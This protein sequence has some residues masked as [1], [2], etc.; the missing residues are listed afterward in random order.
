MVK[1]FADLSASIAVKN[2]AFDF[3][4]LCVNFCNLTALTGFG[5]EL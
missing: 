2:F 5:I 1:M 3:Q 4:Y